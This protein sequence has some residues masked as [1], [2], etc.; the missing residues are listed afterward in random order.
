VSDQALR[1]VPQEILIPGLLLTPVRWRK[2][3]LWNPC[4]VESRKYIRQALRSCGGN[5]IDT[6]TAKPLDTLLR[7]DGLI[8]SDPL[9]SSDN[10]SF[11]LAVSKNFCFRQGEQVNR[12]DV[13]SYI[14]RAA[15]IAFWSL[16]HPADFKVAFS[17]N[18]R[19][20]DGYS[21]R[22]V[23]NRTMRTISLP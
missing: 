23:S 1:F 13:A 15:L 5:R 4:F 20:T 9:A 17:A 18:T 21:L 8:H 2:K 3:I 7:P 12:T 6:L 11:L 19:A 14:D 22:S 10:S 16:S